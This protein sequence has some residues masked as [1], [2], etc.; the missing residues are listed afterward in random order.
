MVVNLFDRRRQKAGGAVKNDEAYRHLA[1]AVIGAA[2]HDLRSKN[3]IVRRDA[4]RFL[5]APERASD[6]GLW[7][8]WLDHTEQS[9]QSLMRRRS[10]RGQPNSVIGRVPLAA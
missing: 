2:V 5:F 4:Q 6:R 3:E 8:A 10:W 1:V 7:L 9:F